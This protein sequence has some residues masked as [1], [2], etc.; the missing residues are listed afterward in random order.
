MCFLSGSAKVVV[1]DDLVI[2]QHDVADQIFH[3]C[4]PYA[5]ILHASA[6]SFVQEADDF[7]GRNL[8]EGALLF[9]FDVEVQLRDL[10]FK[11]FQAFFGLFRD[12]AL[13]DSG[14]EIA[15]RFQCAVRFVSRDLIFALFRDFSLMRRQISSASAL[16]SRCPKEAAMSC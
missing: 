9:L 6:Y 15:G 10:R 4:L 7:F 5:Y 1:D 2:V 16:R 8:G 3:E 11:F 14:Y 12:D 13:F